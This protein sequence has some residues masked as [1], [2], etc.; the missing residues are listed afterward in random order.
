MLGSRI[1]LFAVSWGVLLSEEQIEWDK[2]LDFVFTYNK[3]YR[4]D[5]DELAKRFK[6]FK[7]TRDILQQEV[8]LQN[9]K[10]LGK[11]APSRVPEFIRGE[12]CV[13]SK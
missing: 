3:E 10:N 9:C 5:P 1:I 4:N 11:S 8:W 6:I 12:H 2:F 13:R 7:V